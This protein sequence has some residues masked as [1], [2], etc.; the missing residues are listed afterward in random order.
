MR[1]NPAVNPGRQSR[2]DSAAEFPQDGTTQAPRTTNE[3][4]TDPSKVMPGERAAPPCLCNGESRIGNQ[5]AKGPDLLRQ[6]RE[7]AQKASE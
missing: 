7:K 6:K 4:E 1:G 3:D 5:F 2:F